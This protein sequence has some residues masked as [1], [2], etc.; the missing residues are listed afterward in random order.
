[1]IGEEELLEE[2]NRQNPW[3]EKHEIELKDNLIYREEF[4][5][6]KKEMFKDDI[7]ALIGLRR[8]GKTTIMRQ[9]IDFLLKE[10]PPKHIFYF[11]FDGMKKQETI[12][13]KIIQ[14][15][16]Q[17]ILKE[18]PSNLENQI[19]I[20]LDE[21]QKVK[22]WGEEIKSFW[23]RDYPMKFIISGSSSMNITKGAGESLVGRIKLN[24]THPFSFREFLRFKN[25]EAPSFRLK[26]ILEE[27]L[28]YPA[29]SEELKIRFDQYLENGGFP[30]IYE[31][32]DKKTYLSDMIS[33][34]FYR[35]IVNM[36]PVKRTEVLEG[37]FYYF[38]KESGQ[39]VNYN[40]LSD[41]LNTKYQTVKNYIDHLETSFLIDRSNHHSKTKLKSLRK[42]PKIYVA[43]HGFSF[44]ERMDS[45]LRVETT[46]Y[47]HLKRYY[48]INYWKNDREVDIIVVDDLSDKFEKILPIEVKYKEDI[49]E[50]DLKGLVEFAEKEDIDKS[51]VV[52]KNSLKKENIGDLEVFYVPTWLFLSFQG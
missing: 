39:L 51:I 45:G 28:E 33:L 35:D 49:R 5:E 19:F 15:Y 38:T 11:S 14:I 41:T 43:D 17:K 1:M 21:V 36:L 32:E 7:S 34:T 9:L 10:Q 29:N 40:Q 3:W 13:K 27:D 37:L 42:N 2:M 6:L 26:N 12:V 46:V 50:S 18:V 20:F 22:N 52:T 47:N 44:L 16:Y 31:K 25:T 24:R 30:E 4:P 8:T 48:D 23:D